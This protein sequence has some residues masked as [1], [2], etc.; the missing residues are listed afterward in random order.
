[1]LS[2]Y[3]IST[4][5]KHVGKLHRDLSPSRNEQ[6][7]V[8]AYYS[9]FQSSTIFSEEGSKFLHQARLVTKLREISRLIMKLVMNYLQIV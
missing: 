7:L 3:Y 5:K 1:M 2:N 4:C 8:I 6:A 9:E